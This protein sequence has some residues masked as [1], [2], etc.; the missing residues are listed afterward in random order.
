MYA[1]LFFRLLLQFLKRRS[2][3]KR[4]FF[5]NYFLNFKYFEYLSLLYGYYFVPCHCPNLPPTVPICPILHYQVE[6]SFYSTL[7]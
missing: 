1:P 6:A 2:L 5:K 7:L 3:K 4:L